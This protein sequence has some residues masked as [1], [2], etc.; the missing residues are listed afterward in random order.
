MH[1]FEYFAHSPAEK[2]FI[3]R[4][5]YHKTFLKEKNLSECLSFK[6]GSEILGCSS[7]KDPFVMLSKLITCLSHILLHDFNA[8]ADIKSGVLTKNK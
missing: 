7:S 8:N 5:F 2:P 1:K 3:I 6:F 4:S